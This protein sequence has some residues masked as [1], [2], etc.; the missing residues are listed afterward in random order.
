MGR[1]RHEHHLFPYDSLEE[2]TQERLPTPSSECNV[3]SEGFAS[4][5]QSIKGI[6]A[7]AA[8]REPHEATSTCGKQAEVQPQGHQWSSGSDVAEKAMPWYY[9]SPEEAQA[10]LD[11]HRDHNTNE[12]FP[13]VVVPKEVTSEQ[14]RRDRTYHYLY[15]G[16]RY[17]WSWESHLSVL[18]A[19][20]GRR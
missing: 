6:E 10:S 17:T 8:R 20:P 3:V 9:P 2:Q 13:F 14:L 7:S 15:A 19:G 5:P 16:V 12:L 4:A 18:A 11:D 1:A